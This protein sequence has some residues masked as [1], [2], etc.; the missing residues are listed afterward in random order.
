MKL[1]YQLT[2]VDPVIISQ[3]NATTNNHNTND[4]IPGS[5]ILGAV[6]TQ[7]YSELSD[8]ESW[9]VF[10]SGKVQF[11]PCY[12]LVNG[13]LALPIP[14]SWHVEKGQKATEN[15]QLSA[16]IVNINSIDYDRGE[17]Q[18][19]QLRAGFVTATGAVADVA[20]GQVTKTAI[21]N[22]TGTVEQSQL[23]SYSFIEKAQ[24]F[25]GW[26]EVDDSHQQRVK[27][28]LA[29]VNR[30]GRAKNTEFGRV[31]VEIVTATSQASNEFNEQLVLW[32]A[33]DCEFIDN[34]GHNSLSPSGEMLGQAFKALT[35]NASQSYIRSHH[36]SRFN[37]KRASFDSQAQVISKGSVLVFDLN[38][39]NI[40]SAELSQLAELGIGINKQQGQGW[41]VVNPSWWQSDVLDSRALFNGIQLDLPDA[42][43]NTQQAPTSLMAWV[44]AQLGIA[45]QQQQ[46]KKES[47]NLLADVAASYS[48]ARS[49]NNIR[50]SLQVGP[51]ANQW[52]RIYDRVNSLG[53]K[54]QQGV[55][56][57][58]HAICKASNDEF[59]WGIE[60]Q[61]ADKLTDFASAMEKLLSK[62]PVNTMRLFLEQL[63]QFDPSTYRGLKDLQEYIAKQQGGE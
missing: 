56:N 63:C 13:D 8:N 15:Q 6:A 22:E 21:N 25:I 52:R 60:W 58:E 12:P 53:D 14:A 39:A 57:G 17:K 41:V 45:D 54:W 4:F 59:G 23:Y 2:T 1:Y 18:F 29:K 26:I 20:T 32:C 55:F 9:H 42:P 49:Y 43:T 24:R 46:A 10:H 36:I 40:T 61:G 19:Q 7:L 16:Q 38:G 51:S 62:Q 5:A 27:A 44:Q 30:I 3:T 28:A 35:L 50:N 34:L 11:G 33:A 47:L 37:Q 31:K 48:N